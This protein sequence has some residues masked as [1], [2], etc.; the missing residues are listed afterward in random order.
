MLFEVKW[1]NILIKLYSEVKPMSDN[2]TELSINTEVLKKMAEI[3]AKE[4]DGV[5]GICKKKIDLKGAIKSKTP[6]NGV[7]VE[8]INGAIQ[9]VVYITVKRTANVKTVAE[10]VQ[11]NIKDKI[12]TMTGT[13]VTKV[14]VTVADI[15][16][17]TED[18]E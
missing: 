7:V 8:N 17:E 9:I 3:S 12:Q 18:A 13:A 16:F 10:A 15:Q 14:N 4:V 2:R 11:E 1:Y 6:F 5:V